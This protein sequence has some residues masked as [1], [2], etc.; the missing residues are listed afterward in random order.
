MSVTVVIPT[1]NRRAYAAD[2]VASLQA[3]TCPDLEVVIVDDGST[4]DSV[5]AW[6]G[7]SAGDPRFRVMARATN[8]GPAAARNAGCAAVTSE[9]IAFTDDDCLPEPG[10]LES[11]LRAA[12]KADAEVVQ[13]ATRPSPITPRREL[14]WWSRSQTIPTWS[15]RF[16]TCNLLVRAEAWRTVGGF[17][18]RFPPHGYGEDTDLGLRLVAA[19]CATAFAPDA[20]VHHRVIPMTY[21]EFLRRRYRWAQVVRLVALNPGARH[22]FPL[23]YVAHRSHVA[24]WLALPP[25]VWA[26]RSSRP[27]L[28]VCAALAFGRHRAARSPGKG[29]SALAGTAYGTAELLGVAAGAVGF[30]IESVRHR[31]VLL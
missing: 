28:P 2:V 22:V 14:P 23:R 17:D 21:L 16:Q 30:V 11:L 27:W 8:G 25:A 26:V 12:V 6:C 5:A 24:L 4:D 13:G 9:W 20:V 19:G 31:R 7:A 29:R 1:R 18:E 3:Q 10:W 15:G